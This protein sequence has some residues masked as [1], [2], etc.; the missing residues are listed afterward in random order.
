MKPALKQQIQWTEIRP[1]HQIYIVYCW[2]LR[3]QNYL[4][5]LAF[6]VYK[7][8][9]EAKQW[10]DV[11]SFKCSHQMS[12]VAVFKHLVFCWKAGISHMLLERE[13]APQGSSVSSESSFGPQLS[14]S[15]TQ[16]GLYLQLISLGPTYFL[17]WFWVSLWHYIF[18]GIFSSILKWFSWLWEDIETKSSN[19]AR[20][21]KVLCAEHISSS[22]LQIRLM[23][24][25]FSLLSLAKALQPCY[26]WTMICK[27][28]CL[29]FPKRT[30]LLKKGE[31]N[32]PATGR[33]LF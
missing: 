22:G 27:D 32:C 19:R 28:F 8:S 6:C 21:R 31:G 3:P 26:I 17:L 2:C 1:T 5:S 10:T 33:C 7:M 12:G 20:H 4:E 11:C 25:L 15:P 16:T 13:T 30:F 9:V 24:N 29:C 18:F 23:A 14:V